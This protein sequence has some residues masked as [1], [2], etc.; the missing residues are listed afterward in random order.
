MASSTS[1]VARIPAA[2]GPAVIQRILL[3]DRMRRDRLGTL[4]AATSLPGHLIQLTLTGEA[5]HNVNG[6][7]YL[8]RPGT[9]I[10]FHEDELVR[11]HVRRR[12]WTF[13][14]LNFIAPALG[15]PPFAARVRLVGKQVRQQF[16]RLHR[17]WKQPAPDPGL[18]E[19]RVQAHLLL[20]LSLLTQERTVPFRVD[21]ASQL[22]WDLETTLRVDLSRTINLD[23]MQE[24]TGKSMATIA[25]SCR[26]ALGIAPMKR[27]KQIRLSMAQG[28]TLQSDLQIKEIAR[29]VGYARVHEFSRDYRKHLGRSPSQ[30]RAYRGAGRVGRL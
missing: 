14:T 12:P 25:R 3:C 26:H 19:M 13:L 16:D 6:R 21:P 23:V 7:E 24:I 5:Q 2:V 27:I 1:E 29:R 11:V 8:M 9:L 28:L 22:W 17:I 20:L 30:D 4:G 18:R 15:P 10:W